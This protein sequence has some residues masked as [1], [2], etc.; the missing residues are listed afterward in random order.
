MVFLNNSCSPANTQASP[1]LRIFLWLY[2]HKP[3]SNPSPSEMD[4]RRRAAERRHLKG[5]SLLIA[6]QH[7][8]RKQLTAGPHSRMQTERAS[9]ISLQCIYSVSRRCWS[10]HAVLGKKFGIVAHLL[11][12][13]GICQHEVKSPTSSKTYNIQ[14]ANKLTINP[15][16]RVCWPIRK[17]LESLSDLVVGKNVEESILD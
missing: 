3:P 4:T 11:F 17:L 2:T 16:L 15:K 14:A 6:R 12:D 10:A 9:S 1:E 8:I 5:Q 13:L 7:G